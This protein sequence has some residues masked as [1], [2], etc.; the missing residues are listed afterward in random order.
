[1]RGAED[2][3]NLTLLG[4][5]PRVATLR[6]PLDA[7]RI[8]SAH[9]SAYRCFLGEANISA[10]LENATV[11]CATP[12]FD[13]SQVA[14]P[15][16]ASGHALPLEVSPLPPRPTLLPPLPSTTSHLRPPLPLPPTPTLPLP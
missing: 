2:L 4:A 13:A 11:R 12:P 10:H 7:A 5:D 16:N 8:G 9:L 6:P 3:Y 1:M 14:G 15:G